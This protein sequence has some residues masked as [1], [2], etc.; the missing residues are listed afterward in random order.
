[1]P[2]ESQFYLNDF[3]SNATAFVTLPRVQQLDMPMLF[4][5]PTG[6]LGECALADCL[7]N[8]VCGGKRLAETHFLIAENAPAKHNI[9]YLSVRVTNANFDNVFKHIRQIATTR[10]MFMQRHVFVLEGIEDLHH[11]NQKNILLILD[12]PNVSV[13]SISRTGAIHPA[14]KT[15]FNMIRIPPL[16]DRKIQEVFVQY[17][18]H[19]GK[20]PHPYSGLPK[21]LGYNLRHC[22]LALA[23]PPAAAELLKP[24]DV[25]EKTIKTLLATIARSTSLSTVIQSTRECF[26]LLM[27]YSSDHNLICRALWDVIAKRHA[28]SPDLLQAL[29]P[30]IVELNVRVRHASKPIY[31]Y[32]RFVMVYCEAISG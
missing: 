8:T 27:K 6:V 32:E 18:K 19:L 23:L 13:L 22:L 1:M 3:I 5:D 14:L 11:N 29:L 9:C 2:F 25:F 15:R 20:D 12:N 21:K 28:K 30:M 17:V 10:H 24:R 7:R 4:I 16:P 26:N 31:H